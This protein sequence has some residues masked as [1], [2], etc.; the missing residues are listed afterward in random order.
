VDRRSNLRHGALDGA[1]RCVRCLESP[2]H[3]IGLADRGRSE[4]DCQP[5]TR[6]Q[7]HNHPLHI[8]ARFVAQFT[9]V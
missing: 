5:W 6:S 1:L 8:K 4:L 9:H 3:R 2:K 7:L